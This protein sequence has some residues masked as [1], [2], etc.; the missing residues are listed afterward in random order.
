MPEGKRLRK[1][2]MLLSLRCAHQMRWQ[3][4]SGLSMRGAGRCSV[5]STPSGMHPMTERTIHSIRWY[6]RTRTASR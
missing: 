1:D 2:A 4:Q 3:P 6:R 5:P